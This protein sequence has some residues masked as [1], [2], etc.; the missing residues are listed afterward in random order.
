MNFEKISNFI[1]NEYKPGTFLRIG[2]K[3]EIKLK[4][5]QTV[6]KVCDSLCRLGIDYGC[7]CDNDI[8]KDFVEKTI[9]SLEKY[10]KV[11]NTGKNLLMVYTTSAKSIHTKYYMN[12]IEVKYEDIEND[13]YAKDK[14]K[15]G[16]TNLFT[17]NIE[18]ITSIG[19]L[20]LA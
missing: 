18:N 4:N 15:G 7:F 1:N 2:W 14:S 12:D 8:Q 19:G 11:S 3:R 10:I 9:W 13:M 20:M 6:Y 5:G 17:L 16:I